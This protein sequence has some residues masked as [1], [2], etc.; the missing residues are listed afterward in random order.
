MMSD[1][2]PIYV[3]EKVEDKKTPYN[4]NAVQY[5]ADFKQKVKEVLA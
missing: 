2:N 1:L 4:P 5:T 3:I